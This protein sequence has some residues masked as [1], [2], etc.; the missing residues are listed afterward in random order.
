MRSD[1]YIK[2]EI[3]HD[4]NEDPQRLAEEICRRV[5]KLHGVRLAELSSYVTR[6]EE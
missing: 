1:L 2:V 5:L 3:E 4:E 6:T